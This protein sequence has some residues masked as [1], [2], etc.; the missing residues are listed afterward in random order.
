M[1]VLDASALI[2]HFSAADPH[3]HSATAVVR[4]SGQESLGIHRM[5]LVEVLVGA[6]RVGRAAEL[7]GDVK[8]LGVKTLGWDD[9][10]PLRLATLRVETSLRLPDCCALGAALA[11][12][13]SL[14]TFDARL[15]KVAAAR[16]VA[17]VPEEV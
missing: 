16:G 17:L 13:A 10:E 9:A 15:R 11:H 7:L 12:G 14:A 4:D 8:D 3:H 2:G 1:I 6:A 5:N